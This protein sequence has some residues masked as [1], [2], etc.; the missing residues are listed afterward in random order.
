MK[1]A[2]GASLIEDEAEKFMSIVHLC[3]SLY[4]VDSFNSLYEL[5]QL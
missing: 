2:Q 4:S 3:P 5:Y 1:S